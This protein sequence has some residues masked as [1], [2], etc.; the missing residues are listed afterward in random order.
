M[1]EEINILITLPLA[2][3]LV[4]QIAQV[5]DRFAV[6]LLP[7]R[8]AS[9][10]PGEVWEQAEVLYTMYT[11][12][13]PE[14][15]PN[16]KWVQSYLSGIDK[17]RGEELFKQENIQ[18]TTM[19]GANASQVA[20][21]AVTMIMALGHQLPE[22][23]DLQQRSEWMTSKGTRYIPRELRGSTVG[24]VGYGSIGR[25]IARLV[26][27]FGAKVLA[28]KRDVKQP[29][30]PGYT[31]ENMGDP[32]GDYFT[33]LYPPQAI[34]S[35]F[36]ECDFVVVTV[37][38]TRRTQ[39]LIGPAQIASLKPGAFLVDVSRGGV[40]DHPALVTALTEGKLGGAALDVFPQEP[41]P[42]DHPL[43]SLPNVIITPH[44]AGFSPEYNVRA[45]ELFVENLYRYVAGD[46]LLNPVDLIREY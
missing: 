30:D 46:P 15:S 2:D 21:H 6:T 11:L 22:I 20:E 17:I 32:E 16:L 45:N 28:T 8:E 27:A 31:P 7:A 5:S 9:E 34:R 18:L 43:W 25:Q 23:F 26:H 44:V 36:K 42:T 4:E 38:L 40:V 37:P 35:M 39:G 33:R 3:E 13:E 14:Q 12:P 41:L 29:E 19:S 1:S 10:I 24:I